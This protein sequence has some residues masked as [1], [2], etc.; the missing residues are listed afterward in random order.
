VTDSANKSS[1]ENDKFINAF[2]KITYRAR[3]FTYIARIC[4][5]V[6]CTYILHCIHVRVVAHYI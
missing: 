3:Q 4:H 1:L 5:S 2:C 6:S